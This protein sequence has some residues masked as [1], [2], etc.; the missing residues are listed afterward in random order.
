MGGHRGKKD[1]EETAKFV[2]NEERRER[3]KAQMKVLLVLKSNL[4]SFS[5][6]DF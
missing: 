2:S 3:L 1:K 4:R 5:I 6:D